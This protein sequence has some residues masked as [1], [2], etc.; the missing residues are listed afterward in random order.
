MPYNHSE[1]TQRALSMF[2]QY[3][4]DTQLALLWYGYLDIKDELNPAP[5]PSADTLAK[6]IYGEIKALS[7]DEQLQAQRDILS[8]AE[9]Q[10]GKSYSAL[11]NSARIEVWLLLGQGMESGE[12]INVPSDYKLPEQTHEFSDFIS[13]L[14]FEERVEFMQAGVQGMGAA[15]TTAQ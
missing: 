10:F 4:I 3:D 2:Q 9:S 1:N 15:S 8:G 6:T 11:S 14:S 12:I 13:G 7:Q 5:P